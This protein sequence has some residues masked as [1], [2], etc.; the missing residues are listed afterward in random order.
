VF[1]ARLIKNDQLMTKNVLFT[2]TDFIAIEDNGA[3]IIRQRI[4]GFFVG[5][6]L[7]LIFGILLWWATGLLDPNHLYYK[8]LTFFSFAI[9]SIAALAGFAAIFRYFRPRQSQFDPQQKTVILDNKNYSFEDI[10]SPQIETVVVRETRIETLTVNCQGIK[11]VVLS[12]SNAKALEPLQKALSRIIRSAGEP[13]NS[14]DL[15]KN[16]QNPVL[17]AFKWIMPGTLLTFG[18][19]LSTIGYF[20]I[21]EVVLGSRRSGIAALLWPLG[22]WIGAVGLIDALLIL[23]NKSLFGLPPLILNTL[24]ACLFASYFFVCGV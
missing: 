17:G 23:R 14:I 9:L 4:L 8:L 20:T 2:S 10:T 16:L 1:A 19:L 21:P 12:S 15:E 18:A 7:A 5:I 22:F 3:V 11:K 6:G 24:M 13:E